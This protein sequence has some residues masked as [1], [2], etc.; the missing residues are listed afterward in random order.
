MARAVVTIHIE[1]TSIRL[2]AAVGRRVRAFGESIL[3]S[4]L[5]K[6]GV[7]INQ[8]KVAARIRDL[9]RGQ[10]IQENRVIAGVSGL[11]SLCRVITLPYLSKALLN[12]AVKHEAERVMAVPL[13]QFYLSWQ[14]LSASKDEVKLFLA[15]I[16][17]NTVDA[18]I[19]TLQKADLKP[20]LVDLAPLALV[21]VVNRVTAVKMKTAMVVNIHGKEI[22]I[23][24]L[25]DGVPQLVRSLYLAGELSSMPERL[26][27][28]RE[29]LERT[30]KFYNSTRTEDSW[31]GP[32]PIFVAG[33]VEQTQTLKICQVLGGDT[34]SH[35]FLPLM[36][37]LKWPKD[38]V[39]RQ[40]MVNVGLA[41]KRL[42]S[43][44]GPGLSKV[45]LNI[46]PEAYRPK[47]PSMKRA[48][49][50]AGIGAAVA[51]VGLMA[52][53]V[54]GRAANTE[55]L[56]AQ[57]ETTSQF[58]KDR[59]AE[60]QLQKKQA[61]QMEEQVTQMEQSSNIFVTALDNFHIQQEVLNGDLNTVVDNLPSS[62]M[63][64]VIRHSGS[65]LTV[66]GVA[67][68][69]TEALTYASDLDDSGRFSE[70]VL[71][72]IA[73]DDGSIAFILTIKRQEGA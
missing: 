16:P 63:L 59:Q 30:I 42:A 41:L 55:A 15:A 13:E 10:G 2:L 51:C 44:S 31:A 1:D 66:A 69:E 35:P 70:I 3:E 26:S 21:R 4:G 18:L 65:E 23:V 36:S 33:E 37:P 54:Q 43:G 12:E 29:E 39:N 9:I 68:D 50:T 34:E 6:D 72:R 7:V 17:R 58:L 24:L 5:V 49:A 61:A 14:S 22:D 73:R 52:V 11:H 40:Y 32:I 8:E 64:T 56:N 27:S 20:E 47:P 45:N 25:V 48:F 53:F 60:Q 46:L 62:I 71:T 28:V 57:L 19:T 38:M 67:P